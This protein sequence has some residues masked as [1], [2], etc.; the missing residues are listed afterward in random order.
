MIGREEEVE[1]LRL[2]ID[3]IQD[4]AIYML[5]PTGDVVSWNAGAERIKGYRADEIIG[6]P[7]AKFFPPEDLAGK[8]PQKLLELAAK[9]GRAEDEGWRV[10]KD[11]TIF[12]AS[13]IISPIRDEHGVL[14]GFAK[15]TRDLT[16]RRADEER[17]R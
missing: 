16:E 15:V 5:S 2:L 11:G 17:A 14:R 9:T 13:A 4:H 12:W 3:G 8:K 10:R 7:Y 1:Q 6:Q